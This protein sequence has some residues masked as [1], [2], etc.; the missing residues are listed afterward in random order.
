MSA[1]QATDNVLYLRFPGLQLRTGQVPLYRFKN[2]TASLAPM[3][4]HRY[5]LSLGEQPFAFTVRNGFKGRGGASFGYGAQYC[6]GV[7]G[8]QYHCSLPEFGRESRINAIGD[9]D[10]DGKPDFL[11]TVGGNNSSHEYL[12]LSSLARP[13]KN[14][15]SASLHATGC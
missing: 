2:G 1:L 5:E 9:F 13:G 6:V 14:A 4:D 10:G 3:L 12:L 7:G 11:I 8:Q 15:P